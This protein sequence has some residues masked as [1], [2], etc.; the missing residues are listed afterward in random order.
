MQS[1]EKIKRRYDE[2]LFRSQKFKNL[3]SHGADGISPSTG[4]VA[5][6][7]KIQVL[8][9]PIEKPGIVKIV[10]FNLQRTFTFFICTV[11]LISCHQSVPY[12]VC[13]FP[14]LVRTPGRAE[15]ISQFYLSLIYLSVSI[16]C[17]STFFSYRYVKH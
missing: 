15:I 17:S 7:I 1:Y 9:L 10:S 11:S 6:T 13:T 5:V 12:T 8:R 3:S 2:S 14:W 16:Y 4:A